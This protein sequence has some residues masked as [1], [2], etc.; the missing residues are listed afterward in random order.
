MDE[1]EKGNKQPTPPPPTK[2]IHSLGPMVLKIYS[3]E[4]NPRLVTLQLTKFQ[5]FLQNYLCDFH[6]RLEIK[7]ISVITVRHRVNSNGADEAGTNN[8]LQTLVIRHL[9]HILF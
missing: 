5:D 8:V 3:L 1:S 7:S 2:E 9:T 6:L 4:R